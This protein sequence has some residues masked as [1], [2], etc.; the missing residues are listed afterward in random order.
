MEMLDWKF[1]IRELENTIKKMKTEKLPGKDEIINEFVKSLSITAKKKIL[2]KLN[3]IWVNEIWVN[4]EWPDSW[5]DGLITPI[6]KA[7]DPEDKKNYRGITLLN[8]WVRQ[9][10]PLSPCLFSIFI[11]DLEE[12]W[13]RLNIGGT[14]IRLHKIFCLKFADDIAVIAETREGLQEMINGLER[15]ITQNRLE[16]NTQ[17]S[18]IMVFRRGGRL[19]KSECWTYHGQH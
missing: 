9:G 7:G 16:I 5:W 4:G 12:R 8:T 3:K 15:Y 11:E 1:D 19:S 6:L 2:R 17:K 14:G 10:C 18:Q 13:E